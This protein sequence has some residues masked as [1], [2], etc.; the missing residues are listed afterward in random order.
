[1]FSYICSP[2]TLTKEGRFMQK[3][4][5]VVSF[6]LLVFQGFC[7]Y[8]SDEFIVNTNTVS[9]QE[10]PC[11]AMNSF[12]NFVI[13][14]QSYDKETN[15]YGIYARRFDKDANP[16]GS[17]FR[18]DTT[19][20]DDHDDAA[21]AMSNDIFVITWHS[22]MNNPEKPLESHGIFARCFDME[23]NPLSNEFQ[24]NT[25]KANQVSVTDPSVGIDNSG[26]F[27]IAWDT[28]I[29]DSNSD[30]YA[31]KCDK[32]GNF[33]GSAFRVNS[34]TNYDQRQP[35]VSISETGNFIIA[36]QSNVQDTNSEG[37]FAK[38]FDAA[39]NPIIEEF[40]VNSYFE[41]NQK[42]PTVAMS[43]SRFVVA[44]TGNGSEDRDPSERG[45]YARRFNGP[46]QPLGEDF[47]VNNN[48]IGSEIKLAVDIDTSGGFIISWE[49]IEGGSTMNDKGIFARKYDGTGNAI[50][51]EF[52]VNS[53]IQGSQRYPSLAMTDTN[54]FVITWEGGDAQ[55]GD[56]TGIIAKLYSGEEQKP[57][58]FALHLNPEKTSFTNGD[59]IK[60]LVDM[61]TPSNMVQADLYFVMI[62]PANTLYFGMGWNTVAV[63]LLKNFTVPPNVS[64]K[65]L[66]LLELNIPNTLPVVGAPGTY[67]FAIGATEPGTINFVSN[68]ASASFNVE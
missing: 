4:I 57:F 14:W 54:N 30:V 29:Q 62:N 24:V 20:I 52:Q 56:S 22:K 7:V 44:W 5:V 27:V 25:Y 53:Y 32:F 2:Q 60:A 26:N 38:I 8:G 63:P 51:N 65:D 45:I 55:D 19:T 6:I 39:C 42:Q 46:G 15:L 36:W 68:I 40:Q 1:M 41:Y 12:G 37:I 9:Y 61:Q 64:V 18:V 47:R 59:K 16:L 35:S 23:G 33:I 49:R 48:D 43:G 21:I 10:Y 11:I 50:G 58:E 34:Y 3:L 28:Y 67:I 31:Q 17:D 13:A 66:Q